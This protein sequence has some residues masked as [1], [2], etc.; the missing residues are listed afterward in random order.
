MDMM[1]H[2]PLKKASGG[3]SLEG[4]TE[5][6]NIPEP[7]MPTPN[8]QLRK[9]ESE[10]VSKV[11]SDLYELEQQMPQGGSKI[12]TYLN[13]LHITIGGTPVGADTN[14]PVRVI[15][16]NK[17]QLT[18]IV[19]DS[20]GTKPK[21]TFTPY[22]EHVNNSSVP[23]GTYSIQANN[24]HIL[25]VGAG[26]ISIHTEGNY[27]LNAGGTASINSNYDLS[28]YSNRGD[29]SI[30]SNHNLSIKGDSVRIE[31]KNIDDQVVINSNLGIAR[32]VIVH[33]S[34]Y[35]EGEVYA[36]HM[37]MPT[38]IHDTFQSGMTKG[39]LAADTAIGYV[40]LSLLI[41]AIRES[42]PTFSWTLPQT[43]PIYTFPIYEL[44]CRLGVPPIATGVNGDFVDVYPHQHP[45]RTVSA[46]ITDG[47]Q[48]VRDVAK[49]VFN[50]GKA[51]V[52]SPPKHGGDAGQ[53]MKT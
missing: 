14:P 12:I 37:T 44:P 21:V 9:K 27:S 51:G 45:Y 3:F 24:Q 50:S 28:I 11:A 22:T 2:N 4:T 5:D 38:E 15:E 25:T 13:D 33:G 20:D 46:S 34:M 32:N 36:Q 10:V 53:F 40:D 39:Q 43:F 30:S 6:I 1:N 48:S 7:K 47:N 41:T 18:R 26:G 16:C 42:L 52:A 19:L 49:D 23:F 31:T 17:P 8:I 35:V 29:M